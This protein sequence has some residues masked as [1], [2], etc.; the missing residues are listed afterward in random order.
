MYVTPH[1]KPYFLQTRTGKLLALGLMLSSGVAN[2]LIMDLAYE[3]TG[4]TAVSTI[5][6]F[7]LFIPINRML[8]K[9][10]PEITNRVY[11][12]IGF[13][14][15]LIALDRSTRPVGDKMLTFI[16]VSMLFSLGSLISTIKHTEKF[17][18]QILDQKTFYLRA[19]NDYKKDDFKSA[20]TNFTDSISHGNISRDVYYFRGICHGMIDQYPE[21]LADLGI[22]MDID[23]A[24]EDVY[25]WRGLTYYSMDHADQRAVADFERVLAQCAN[26][27]LKDHARH[28][29]QALQQAKK[30]T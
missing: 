26:E 15:V 23:P 16:S 18:H 12:V 6:F 21:A 30:H 25:F 24:F 11:F 9:L 2:G 7:L 22:V 13:Y 10:R 5:I 1:S 19:I 27:E 17:A 28:H 20:I 8:S 3:K 29:L 4:T 14:L